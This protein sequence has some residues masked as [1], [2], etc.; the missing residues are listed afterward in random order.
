MQI[1]SQAKSDEIV[2][3][4]VSFAFGDRKILEEVSFTVRTGETFVLV[5]EC[6][7]GKSTLLKLCCA[8]LRPQAG[9]VLLKGRDTCRV[10]QEELMKIR[11]DIGYIFQSSALISNMT[12]FANI[13]LPLLYHT[14]YPLET[15]HTIVNSR[16]ELLNLKGYENAMPASL[17][18]GVMK[19]AGVARALA[20]MP[21]LMLYDEPTSALDPLNAEIMNGMI[22]SLHSGFGVTSVVVTHDVKAALGLGTRVA[23]IAH[24]N[25]IFCG[26]PEELRQSQDKYIQTFFRFD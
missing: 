10:P 7:F 22:K 23:I 11:L 15:I 26:T 25:I 21:N 9:T 4:K 24:H 18:M 19:R 13:A 1:L 20:L 12:V 5:G 16:I 14:N 6:G 2:F 8:L 3:D 17:S